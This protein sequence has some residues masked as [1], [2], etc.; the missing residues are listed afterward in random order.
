MKISDSYNWQKLT[1]DDG[2]YFFGYYDRCPWNADSSKHLVIKANQC[3][4]LPVQNEIA[5]IGYV[6][7]N[8]FDYIKL[9]ETRAWCHQQG[10]MQQWLKHKSD[11]F[12]YN[13]YDKS[14]GK[15]I[16]KIYEIGKGVTGSYNFPI[17]AMSPDGKWGAALNFARIPRRG[18][19]Y[20][21]AVLEDNKQA[22]LDKDG[23]FLVNLHSV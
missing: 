22:N 13:G 19:S 3:E 14:K 21:N 12:I 9:T 11:T 1:K 18:Y 10:S 20:A 15:L 6:D 2:H 23:V 4:Q 8:T 7:R 17:Y 16:A 5:E